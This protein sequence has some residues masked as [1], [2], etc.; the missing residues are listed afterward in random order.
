MFSKS[1]VILFLLVTSVAA[2]NPKFGQ[3]P[4][5]ETSPDWI[6]SRSPDKFVRIETQPS[7][8]QE[9]YLVYFGWPKLDQNRRLRIRLDKTLIV[10]GSEQ[11]TFNH[12]VR[13]N[14]TLT[15]VFD[16]LGADDKVE[17]T[18]S[19]TVLVPEDLVINASNNVLKQDLSKNI[20]RLFLSSEFPLTT[21]GFKFEIRTD[22]I[23]SDTGIIQTFGEGTKA[24]ADTDGRPG[25]AII[26]SSKYAQGNLTVF[27]RGEFGG[28]GSKGPPY[29]NRAAD[30]APATG[31]SE[32]CSKEPRLMSSI[33]KVKP[34]ICRCI[35]PGRSATSG[36]SGAKGYSGLP[37]RNGGDAGTFKISVNDG[38]DFNIDV[39]QL[40]GA[41]G[42]PGPGGD[43]QPGGIGGVGGSRSDC[44]GSA[45]A[46]GSQG[47]TGD[48]GST[49]L[50]G[51]AGVSCIYVASLQ[52]NDCNE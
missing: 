20:Q 47:P 46:N 14:Q 8:S 4:E 19:K 40:P 48:S 24:A 37:A 16:I 49:A 3:E 31:G 9:K 12:E 22:Q 10:V 25:G 52:R 2:C 41:A 15:Y 39:K 28:D 18:F 42:N 38:N 1:N 45:G 33:K 17:R 7:S 32:D 30:G 43:G 13:H 26:I 44:V 21:N 50:N 29:G 11:S 27:M 34:L 36:A 35:S 23:I 5:E 51:S 6:I